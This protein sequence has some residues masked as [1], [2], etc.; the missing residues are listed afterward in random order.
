[1]L[2]VKNWILGHSL[3]EWA[4]DHLT[5]AHTGLENVIGNLVGT[6]FNAD[7]AAGAVS[8]VHTARF[9]AQ[10]HGE[11][12]QVT[13]YRFDLA[14]GEEGNIGMLAYLHHFRGQDAGGAVQG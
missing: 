14:P 11:V 1:M 10:G 9:L 8:F 5:L 6:F 4:V 2:F 7:T 12:T 3:G 13:I